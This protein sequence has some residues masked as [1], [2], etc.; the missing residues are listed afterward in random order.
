[1][2]WRG[3]WRRRQKRKRSRWPRLTRAKLASKVTLAG[4]LGVVGLILFSTLLFAWYAKDLPR[5][6]RV[7]RREGFSTK[8]YDR[9]EELLYDVFADQRRTPIPLDEVPRQIAQADLGIY[10]GLSDPHMDI[11]MP[12]KVL[13][14]AFMG[15]PIIASRLKVLKDSFNDTAIMFFEPGSVEQFA[16][17]VLELYDNPSRR[18]ELVRNMDNLFVSTHSLSHERRVYFDLLNHLLSPREKVIPVD[19]RE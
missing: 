18:D 19:E 17:C 1:M 8:I 10:T 7:V 14:Y 5:P 13:E 3:V 11:A 16:S 4:L 6:D 9:N 15:I 2:T 12:G